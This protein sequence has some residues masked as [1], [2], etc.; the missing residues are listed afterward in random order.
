MEG[1]LYGINFGGDMTQGLILRRRCAKGRRASRA[2]HGLR[3]AG[4]HQ[5]ITTTTTEAQWFL[6]F[7]GSE[8]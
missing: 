1:R 8:N 6:G 7:K 2:F 3:L 4:S 5:L